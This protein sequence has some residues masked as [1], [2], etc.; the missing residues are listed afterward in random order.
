MNVL[1]THLVLVA[2]G[3]GITPYQPPGGG[4]IITVVND[5]AWGAFAACLVGF[6]VAA[7]TMAWKHR[8]GE[9]GA[10]PRSVASA[11]HDP[12]SSSSSSMRTGPPPSFPRSIPMVAPRPPNRKAHP[13]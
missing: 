5:V 13:Q 1:T 8:R 4:A 11:A 9:V 12:S 6:I 7:A 3:S 2:G 10:R